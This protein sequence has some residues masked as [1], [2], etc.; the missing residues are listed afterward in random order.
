MKK[1]KTL[2][3]G[4]VL[5]F[6][7]GGGLEAKLSVSSDEDINGLAPVVEIYDK[8]DSQG[9]MVRR[10]MFLACTLKKP[11]EEEADCIVDYSLEALERAL[12]G[13]SNLKFERNVDDYLSLIYFGL[14]SKNGEELP[15]STFVYENFEEGVT[16]DHVIE[17]YNERIEN[18]KLYLEKAAEHASKRV[19]HLKETG[20]KEII[21]ISRN[22]E[23]IRRSSIEDEA[24]L[25]WAEF[26]FNLYAKLYEEYND[27]TYFRE[28]ERLLDLLEGLE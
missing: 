7:L 2:C 27:Y 9:Y 10:D 16:P 6:W 22:N 14:F 25:N 23:V 17:E 4:S 8:L 28:A 24:I 12:Y 1:I 15:F 19:E 3:L 11:L 18:R 5:S 20:E 13:F 21:L 26:A